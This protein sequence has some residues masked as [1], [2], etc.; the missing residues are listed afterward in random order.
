MRRLTRALLATGAIGLAVSLPGTATAGLESH[1]HALTDFTGA[2][3]TVL[4]CAGHAAE[5]SGA[6]RL[7]PAAKEQ[8]GAAW[9]ATPIGLSGE[10]GFVSTFSFR[11]DGGGMVADGLA[12]VIAR[13]PTGLGE[14][15][16]Y[17]GS[18]G[19]EEVA[20]SLAVEFDTFD[21]GEPG[22]DNHVALARDGVLASLAWSNPYSTTGCA[23]GGAGCMANG[24]IWT[25]TVSY[26][27]AAHL[28]SVA[29]R[30]GDDPMQL[31]IADYA[32]DLRDVVGGDDA[33]LGFSAGTG[34]GFMNHDLLAWS[35]HSGPGVPEAAN[36]TAVPEPAGAVLLG[37]ALAGLALAR[38][39]RRS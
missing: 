5:V 1:A 32:V 35:L 26:D 34:D 7:V 4:V 22:R 24:E 29:L 15:A 16:R 20:D 28:F 3:G 18:M 36:T 8:A 23:A 13:D 17:G 12:F 30:Q 25:A 37:T 14:P 9:L 11:F 2:C 10:A 27:G 21:N 31:L 38:R 33:W 39:P 19:F 6:L